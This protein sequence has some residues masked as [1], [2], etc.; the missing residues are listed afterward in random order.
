M[1]EP[2]LDRADPPGKDFSEVRT[3]IFAGGAAFI[4]NAT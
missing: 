1:A 2:S 4:Q 3:A